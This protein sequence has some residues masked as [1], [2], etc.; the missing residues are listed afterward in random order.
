[1][2]GAA[3]S[4]RVES[5]PASLAGGRYQLESPLGHGASATVYRALDKALDGVVAL[6]LASSPA[7]S[8][9]FRAEAAAA[10]Q[11]SHPRIVRVHNYDCDLPWEFLVM[12]CV[13]GPSLN[14]YR[15][16]RPE[17]RLSAAETLTIGLECL[18]ALEHAH[19]MGIAHHDVKP[20]NILVS[21]SGIKLCDFGLAARTTVPHP[22]DAKFVAGT[23]P[24]S[25]PSGCAARPAITAATSTRSRPP[26]T[27]WATAR[28]CFV[29]RT[30][31]M[32]T[33]ICRRP[34]PR[35]CRRLSTRCYGPRW[36]RTPRAASSPRRRCAPRCWSSLT[37]RSGAQ[38]RSRS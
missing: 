31:T 29:R 13:D 4:A 22:T 1:M 17:K 18:E 35:I 28:R 9:R 10:M 25:A 33:S 3:E 36:P 38:P 34:S 24:T 32:D 8:A 23:P 15:Q 16:R 21:R 5:L 30:P 19:E 37:P 14:A 12:E 6:K 26:C 2:T 20:G 7:M 11:L 27:R